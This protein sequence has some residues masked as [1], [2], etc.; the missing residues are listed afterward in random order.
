MMALAFHLIHGFKSA[1]Q[2]LGLN[3]KKYNQLIKN[4]GICVFGI[5]VPILFAAMPI[6]FLL[7]NH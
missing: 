6:Y 5:I 2:T 7:F 4:I 1:F 3:H